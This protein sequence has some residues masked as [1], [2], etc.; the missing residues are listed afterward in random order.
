MQRVKFKVCIFGNG[1]VGKTTLVNRYL[2]GLFKDNLAMTI[3]ADFYVKGM[4]I[5]GIKVT[6][7][8]WDFAGEDRFR[9]IL[10]SYIAGASGCIFMYDI[11]R[12]K[13]LEDIED[14][15]KVFNKGAQQLNDDIPLIMLG[16]KLDLQDKRAAPREDA[17]EIAKH[18][19]FLEYIECS[20]KTGENVEQVFLKIG[21]IMLKKEGLL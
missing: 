3:G 8:I 5:D 17:I 2:T 6:L 20:S 4:E 19:N 14:W 15:M 10:P 21:Q 7:Q 13:S 1:G 9:F 12:Y 18:Y 11:T 16:G